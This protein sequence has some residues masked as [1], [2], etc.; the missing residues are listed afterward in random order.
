[1]IIYLIGG[2]CVKGE[3]CPKGS[4]SPRLCTPG[5]YCNQDKLPSV[6]GVC[7]E[8]YYCSGGTKDKF[9]VNKTYGDICPAGSYC[10]EGSDAP[11]ACLQGFFAEGI[12]NRFSNAC[13]PCKY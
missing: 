2:I 9:S 13:I 12:G 4:T 11:T 5:F 3:F 7:P 6:S 10:P 8:G 1:M